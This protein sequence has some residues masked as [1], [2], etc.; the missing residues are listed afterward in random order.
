M[1]A[2]ASPGRV[3]HP[4]PL[5]PCHARPPRAPHPALSAH[6]PLQVRCKRSG[7]PSEVLAVE[8]EALPQGLEWGEV[9]LSIRYAPVNPA[10]L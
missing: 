6:V 7:V 4:A 3:R 10:D 1:T 5:C 9:L 8:A 2:P